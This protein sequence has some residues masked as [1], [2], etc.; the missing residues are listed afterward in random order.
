MRVKLLIPKRNSKPAI[1]DPQS[2]IT[3]PMGTSKKRKKLWI[4]ILI[5]IV[6]GASAAFFVSSKRTKI[7]EV[8]TDK[9]K[10]Q[11]LVSRVT[12]SGK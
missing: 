9:V 11:R 2:E 10:T 8:Q 1:R 6:A 4:V 12:A 3:K 7:T 5:L